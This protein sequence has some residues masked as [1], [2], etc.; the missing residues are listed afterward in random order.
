MSKTMDTATV[1]NYRS[2]QTSPPRH[3]RTDN[4]SGKESAMEKYQSIN[5]SAT[6]EQDVKNF[7][8][9]FAR[10]V[11]SSHGIRSRMTQNS[12]ANM[13]AFS[14]NSGGS[15]SGKTIGQL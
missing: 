9:N 7:Q 10:Q 12:R 5:F 2:L 14:A 8:N 4:P 3:K 6:L 15:I 11:K 1:G 13:G